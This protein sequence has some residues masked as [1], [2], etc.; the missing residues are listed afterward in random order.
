MDEAL[1]HRIMGFLQAQ[2]DIEAE[3]RLLT[4]L[5]IILFLLGVAAGVLCA[6][7]FREDVI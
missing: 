6:E 4:I 3:R 5:L 7:A 2:K 1:F